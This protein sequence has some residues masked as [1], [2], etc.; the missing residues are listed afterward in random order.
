LPD[1][2]HRQDR[3]GTDDGA[4]SG[5]GVQHAVASRASSV[6]QKSPHQSPDVV[7]PG[8]HIRSYRPI[9]STTNG[10]AGS[11]NEA[12]VYEIRLTGHLDARWAAWFDGLTLTRDRDGTTVIR[13]QVVDQAALHGLLHKV[14]DIGLPLVSVAR[15][16]PASPPTHPGA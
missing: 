16:D 8:H 13:G 14:R 1:A 11:W 15:I 4:D 2:L 5:D 9:M 6:H 7:M 3:G 10:S 12:G